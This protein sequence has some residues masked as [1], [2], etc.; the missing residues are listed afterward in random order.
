[1]R[2]VSDTIIYKEIY[3]NLA[4]ASCKNKE[5]RTLFLDKRVKVSAF[6]YL[7][8]EEVAAGW[9]KQQWNG[10]GTKM[11]QKLFGLS[12]GGTG[13]VAVLII[14]GILL[15][16][17]GNSDFSGLAIFAGVIIG[18]TLGVLGVFGVIMKVFGRFI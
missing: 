18:I 16:A 2:K 5:I 8:E 12:I 14:A 3:N 7:V 4:K 10:G 11:V 6:L 9:L 15:S 17:T 1:M 13:I